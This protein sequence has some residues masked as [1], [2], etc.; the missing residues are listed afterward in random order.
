MPEDNLNVPKREIS[1]F[2]LKAFL[3]RYL[4]YWWL[5]GLTLVISFSIARYYNWYKNPIY[6]ISAKLLVKDEK[7]GRQQLLKELDVDAP[8]KN[9]ENEI[10]ILRSHSL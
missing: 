9:I 5:F 7:M 10:E 8:S 4:R 6:T 2:E 3:G 1:E